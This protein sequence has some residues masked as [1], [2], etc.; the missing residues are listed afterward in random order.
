[1]RKKLFDLENSLSETIK[2]KLSKLDH[3]LL[4]QDAKMFGFAKTNKFLNDLIINY[5]DEFYLQLEQATSSI[6]VGMENFSFGKDKT[7]FV[8]A[9]KRTA[10][11][12]CSHTRSYSKDLTSTFS[13]TIR[14]S[15]R[16][17]IVETMYKL[18]P[19]IQISVF[20]RSLFKSYLSLPEYKRELIVF[21]ELVDKLTPLLKKNKIQYVSPGKEPRFLNPYSI[22][23]SNHEL[24]NYLIGESNSS[25]NIVSI[26]LM[27]I[28]KVY[29][30]DEK[31]V[32]RD[33]FE[34]CFA[35]MSK[36]GFQFSI[37]EISN[38]TIKLTERGYEIFNS[39]FIDR[40]TPEK[41]EK[42]KEIYELT[43]K[44]S[45]AQLDFYFLPF[46]DAIID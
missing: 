10:L 36:N 45:Q 24:R 28:G 41:V 9:A 6:L 7:D 43:F 30:T 2:V 19:D 27:N 42:K 46:K 26:R 25:H 37:N 39:R 15:S 33:D 29:A 22:E 35:L 44:S 40:P 12:V 1:M 14:K 20:F 21:K 23:H 4:L 11:D 32:F 16:V 3:D 31:A 8:I 38:K 18:D 34:D 5:I 13:I 17:A